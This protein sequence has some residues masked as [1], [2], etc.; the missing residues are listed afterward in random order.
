MKK[1]KGCIWEILS[2]ASTESRILE[3]KSLL[4]GA[5]GTSPQVQTSGQAS[6]Q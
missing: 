1:V 6:Y 5:L 2:T 4:F 3:W